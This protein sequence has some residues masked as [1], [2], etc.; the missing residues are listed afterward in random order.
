MFQSFR[1]F[2][3]CFVFDIVGQFSELIYEVQF[4]GGVFGCCDKLLFLLLK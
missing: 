1:L 3:C 2:D 4:K